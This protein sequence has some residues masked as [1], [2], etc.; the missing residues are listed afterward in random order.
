LIKEKQLMDQKPITVQTTVNAPIE[1][2][3]EYWSAPEHIVGWAFASDDWEARDP[4]NDLR[5]GGKFKTHMAAKDGSAGFD[6]AGV[7]T[8]VREHELIAYD[9]DDGRHVD[10]EFTQLPEGVEV[11]QTF[12]PEDENPPD[13]QRSGWQAFLDNFKK[14]A[15]GR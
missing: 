15:E 4:E 13:F 11:K 10:T 5:A 12:D 1:K 6:F 2:V 8:A 3:W 9:L 7:Y 14:Y